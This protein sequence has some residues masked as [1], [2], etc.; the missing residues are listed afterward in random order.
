M[1]RALTLT[2]QSVQSEN[3]GQVPGPGPGPGP[4]Q[5]LDHKGQGPA[6][7]QGQGQ[8][9]ASA[10]APGPGL[11]L[12]YEFGGPSISMA[13]AALLLAQRRASLGIYNI[14]TSNIEV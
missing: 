3:N 2:R 12:G 14:Y 8:G 9:L 10:S 6:Q 11:E 13:E 7:G 1:N 5:G 4:G